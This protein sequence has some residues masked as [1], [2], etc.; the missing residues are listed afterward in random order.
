[1]E[2]EGFDLY[3]IGIKLTPAVSLEALQNR[4]KEALGQ[5]GYPVQPEEVP[6]P[7]TRLLPPISVLSARE[8]VRIELNYLASALNTIGQ[9]P[10]QVS[11]VFA[12]LPIILTELGFE[13]NAVIQFYEVVANSFVKV[14]RRPVDVLSFAVEKPLRGFE[15]LGR[16]T[17]SALRTSID[18][19]GK[20]ILNLVVEP[21]PTSP[22]SRLS[23]KLQYRSDN[24]D[25][26]AGFHT[27]I[28]DRMRKFVQSLGG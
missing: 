3:H 22:N 8:G 7:R 14:D 6:D 1:M 13:L 19:T 12:D 26:I 27:S 10:D 5:R 25:K 23:L 2:L 11:K 20:D 24:K 16:L 28:V 18:E 4:M 15:D 17:V 9:S 21:N